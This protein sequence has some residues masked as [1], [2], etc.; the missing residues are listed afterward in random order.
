MRERPLWEASFAGLSPLAFYGGIGLLAGAWALGEAPGWFW[1]LL[2]P[3]WRLRLGWRVCLY[4]GRLVLKPPLGLAR[5]VPWERVAGVE[6]GLWPGG[7]LARARKA[8]FLLLE[9]GENLPLPLP[10]PE[11]LAERLRALLEGRT[12]GSGFPDG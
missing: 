2:Y 6:V 9:D 10:E 8:L 12:S 7:P 3:W 11:A 4:P 1:L 5:T